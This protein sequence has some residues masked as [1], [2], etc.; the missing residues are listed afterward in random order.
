MTYKNLNECTADHSYFV[1]EVVGVETEGKV[2]LIYLC[3][4][5]GDAVCRPFAVSTPGNA[6]RLMRE[7]KHN[8]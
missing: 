5:C 7:E 6:I 3:T 2:F 1:C 4:R 8:L